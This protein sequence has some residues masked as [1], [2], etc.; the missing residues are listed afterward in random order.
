MKIWISLV[1][2]IFIGLV[3]FPA[4]FTIYISWLVPTSAGSA[5]KISVA[6]KVDQPVEGGSSVQTESIGLVHLGK[7]LLAAEF[8]SDMNGINFGKAGLSHFMDFSIE[9]L[10]PQRALN[11]PPTL[12]L[13]REGVKGMEADVIL[14]RLKS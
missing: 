5:F 8:D 10:G 14:E 7:P 11:L 13:N 4:V 6:T 1:A 9:S 3:L 12:F 2:V